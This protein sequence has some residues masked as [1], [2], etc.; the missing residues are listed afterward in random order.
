MSKFIAACGIVC[1]ECDVL[2]ATV[3]N[4]SEWKKR[5]AI[6]FKEQF[7][8]DADA[9]KIVCTGCMTKSEPKLGYC[10][11]CKIRLCCISKGFG[12]CSECADFSC[13]KTEEL[14][15]MA[16][17]AKKIIEDIKRKNRPE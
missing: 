10:G 12:N 4:D 8:M 13:D 3:T 9:E 15:K 11:E 7:G 16:P 14:F 1:N 5:L 6:Q 2:L 17:E